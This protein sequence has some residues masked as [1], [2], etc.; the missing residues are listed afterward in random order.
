MIPFIGRKREL[1]LLSQLLEKRTSSMVVIKGRRRIGKT[2]LIKEFGKSFK[3]Y[4]FTGLP[5][6]DGISLLAQKE[7]FARQLQQQLQVPSPKADDWGTLFWH[8]G[9]HTQSGKLLIVLDEINWMGS[10]DPTF[11]GKLKTAWD[12]HFKNNPQ[13]ILILCGSISSW[14][15][16][17]ILKSTGFFGRISMTLNLEELSLAECNL[18]W[19]NQKDLVSAYD[20]FKTLSVLGGI[21]KYL[22]EINPDLTAEENIRRLCFQTEGLL[23]REFD[24]IFSDLFSKKNTVYKAIVRRLAEGKAELEDIFESL[25]VQKNGVIGHYLDDLI[26]AGFVSRDFT[27]N[28]QNGKESK[29]SH[30]R[31]RDNYLRF[32]L[33]YIEPNKRKIARGGFTLPSAWETS[34]GLQFENLVLNNRNTLQNILKIDPQEIESDNPYFQRKTS[35]QD[36][37]QID[38]LIQTK[39]DLYVCEIKFTAGPVKL[40]VLDELEQ[41]IK[42]LHAPTHFSFRPVLIHVNGVHKKVIESQFFS[43]IIDFSDLFL[44]PK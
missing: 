42:R 38:Y 36:G 34:L 22:E 12:D 8:L 13:L 24:S 33:K 3:T 28:I 1:N 31:L 30:Y 41:K 6:S 19:Q 5:P 21:P 39:Q 4:S 43:R 20:K 23:F 7:E 25:G 26:Q 32:Y 37:C 27:W 35:K 14:I 40:S 2:R 11:L 16:E 10:K 29:F 15:E 44:A 9:H 17:N 18:F